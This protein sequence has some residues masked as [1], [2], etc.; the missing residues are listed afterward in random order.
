MKSYQAY[1]FAVYDALL[2]LDAYPDNAQAMECYNKYQRL[3]QRAKMEY[4][5]KYGP[6]TAPTEANNWHWTD[7]PW[8][9]HIEG[10]K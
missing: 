4:E 10:G 9:W 8:P 7:S 1:S 6:I 3:A 5:A 2:Y